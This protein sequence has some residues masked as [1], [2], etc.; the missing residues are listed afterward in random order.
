MTP[1]LLEKLQP[2]SGKICAVMQLESTPSDTASRQQ[3]A[4]HQ[5]AATRPSEK[6]LADMKPVP[7]TE[8]RFTEVPKRKYPEGSTP[9]EMSKYSMDSSYALQTVLDTAYRD[10]PL[11]LLGEVQFAFVCFLVGQVY[12]AFEQWKKL[13]HL[14]CSCEEAITRHGELYAAFIAMLHYHVREIPEDFFVDIVARDNFLVAVLRTFF[15][16]LAESGGE[17]SLKN[18]GLRFKE[19][20]EKKFKWDLSA[21]NEEDEPVIVE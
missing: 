10:C 8:I 1:D 14:L 19:H 12:D 9:S 17:E 13:V 11:G 20:L 2:L 7:G 4:E 3:A 21:E 16:N 6:D 5:T 15:E 18:R